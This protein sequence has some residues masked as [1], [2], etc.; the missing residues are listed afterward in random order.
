M[1]YWLTIN[2]ENAAIWRRKR[3]VIQSAMLAAGAGSVANHLGWR[4]EMAGIM[5][6]AG[7]TNV[8]LCN[9]WLWPGSSAGLN[10]VIWLASER[11][12]NS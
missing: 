1:A 5:A 7:V 10:G 8:G 6:K 11:K 4:N 2:I 9:G 3:G 12:R